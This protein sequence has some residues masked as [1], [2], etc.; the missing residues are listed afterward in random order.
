M[1]EHR[2]P[3]MTQSSQKV[4]IHFS[5]WFNQMCLTPDFRISRFY[6][7]RKN[8]L[9]CIRTELSIPDT[10]LSRW[11]SQHWIMQPTR[12]RFIISGNVVLKVWWDF[13]RGGAYSAFR[14]GSRKK[15]LSKLRRQKRQLR[16]DFTADMRYLCWRERNDAQVIVNHVPVSLSHPTPT[17]TNT[18]SLGTDA[19]S[20]R[21]T[22]THKSCSPLQTLFLHDWAQTHPHPSLLDTL[23]HKQ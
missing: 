21:G 15:K 12:A 8:I 18:S 17:S 11:Q 22:V 7:I 20:R 1:A 10:L 16:A 19:L 6:K 3:K 2:C 23:K 9:G 14:W 5:R 13:S 4:K